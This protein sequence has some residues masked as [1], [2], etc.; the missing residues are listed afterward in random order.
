M[1]IRS[2]ATA[3]PSDRLKV[4]ISYSR[5]DSGE[6]ADELL[7]GLELAGFSPFLDRH[8]IAAGEEWETRLG[9]LIRQADTVVYVISPESVKSP[10]CEWE[11]EKAITEAKR[12]LPVIFKSVADADVP[13]EL[14][15]RQF[16]HFDTGPGITRPLTQLADALRQDLDWIRE[17]T[18]LSEL[19]QR[20][21]SRDRPASL[22]LRNDELAV[23]QA[24]AERWKPGTP[25]V[26]DVVQR[27]ITASKSQEALDRAQSKA[28]RH[29]MRWTE[30][31]AAAFGLAAF[32]AI[33]G[34]WQ[35]SWL[36]QEFYALKNVQALA[37]AQEHTLKPQSDF[38]ECTDCPDMVVLPAGSFV[39]GSPPTDPARKPSEEPQ[40]T[41]TIATPFAVSKFEVTFAQWDA[42][43][44]NGPCNRQVSDGGFGRGQ[45]PV[46]NVT[47]S[48]AE[49]YVAWLSAITGKSYRLLSE[50]EY[51]YASRGGTTTMYPWGDAIGTN[52]ANCAGCGS[53]WDGKQPAPVGSFSPN[54]FG[55]YD[56]IG[57]VWEWTADCAHTTYDG[58]PRDGSSWVD[59]N[60]C[61]SRVA[62]GGSWNVV[63]AS[64]RSADRLL[65]TAGSLY[66]N[67]GFRVARTLSAP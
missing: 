53:P 45:Q 66:F 47:W 50:A 7:A 65:I 28:V 63:P 40:R 61:S 10:R 39:M 42:C 8:D 46:V 33:V 62:R 4:F 13:A 26:T 58:A 31:L 30:F 38:K 64:L 59:N 60:G 41:V 57:N 19:A 16:I 11:V 36:K 34:W 25:T 24:W 48:D 43:A 15:R 12:V 29:R 44:A 23:A 3:T 17:H 56:M 2:M 51:E 32:L 20:W 67:L 35:Q 14:Q 1:P 21:D 18:R 5:R 49:R 9:A 27:L 54:P 52:N 22:L 55:L 6:F 37:A